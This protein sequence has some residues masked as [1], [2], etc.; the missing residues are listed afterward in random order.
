MR[1]RTKN[2]VED[3]KLGKCR[4]SFTRDHEDGQGHTL[5]ALQAASV[6]PPSQSEKCGLLHDPVLHSSD[7]LQSPGDTHSQSTSRT[8][9]SG[10]D[11]GH[12][13]GSLTQRPVIRP[14]PFANRS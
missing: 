1:Q 13:S 14:S 3:D 8:A 6:T 5:P 10:G 11:S 12:P 9:P 2:K 4:S 7:R